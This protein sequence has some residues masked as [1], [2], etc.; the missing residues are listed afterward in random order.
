LQNINFFATIQTKREPTSQASSLFNNINV[1][2]IIADFGGIR[3]GGI[4]MKFESEAERIRYEEDYRPAYDALMEWY[5]FALDDHADEV[6]KPIAGYE[7]F[8]HVSN[9]GRI[10]SFYGKKPRILKPALNQKGYLY[11]NL[12][13]GGET[14][15]FRVHVLV[16]R[17]FIPNPDNKPEVNH[18]IGWK[19]NCYVGNLE[20]ATRAENQQHAYDSGLQVGHGLKGTEHGRAKI[21]D[22]K[23]IIYIRENPDGLT[24]VEL[25]EKFGVDERTISAIQLGKKWQHVGGTVRKS[26]RVSVETKQ[27]IRADWATGQYSQRQLAKMYNVTQQTISRIINE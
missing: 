21:K 22:E 8:Y 7:E 23:I 2:E 26:K 18:R 3:K 10:K 19:L 13:M 14:K 6:W 12:S 4:A 24:T 9:Y 5:P 1:G 16:A 11:V 15:N 25:A 27:L 20:W 17:A